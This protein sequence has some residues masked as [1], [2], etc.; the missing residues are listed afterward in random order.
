MNLK[1]LLVRPYPYMPTSKWLQTM[2]L[3][4]PYA[5]ELIAGAVQEPH[6][7]KICDLAVHKKP[8][9]AFKKALQEYQPD[10][11]GFGG[12][13]GQFRTNK[14]LAA[15]AKKILPE[16]VVCI[17][18]IHS[19]S[20][21]LDCKYPE[22]FDLVV[23]GDGVSAIKVIIAAMERGEKLP[24]SQWILQPASENFDEL[25]KKPPPALH[26]DGINT[27]PRRDLIDVS[28]Y[29]CLCYG[30]PGRKTKTLFPEI[31]CVRTSVGCPNRCSFCVVHF[32]ASGK[33]LQRK[34]EDVVD[35]IESLPQEYIYFVDDETFINT[36]RMSKIAEML[37]A[38]GIKKKYLSWARSDTICNHPEL[39]K[40]WKKAGL[41]FVYIGFES[42]K[43]E[44][45]NAYNKNATPSQNR[46][47]R[48]ILRDLNLNIHAALMINPD[49]EEEDFITVQKT[50]KEMA[51]AEFAFTIF[52]PP[53][54]TNDFHD[55]QD[56]FIC[57]DPCL[58]YDC[59]HTILPTKLP[60]RRF[61]RYFAILYAMGAAYVP[62]R[63]NK[64][65]VP[66]RDLYKFIWKGIKFG[67]HLKRL[68]RDYDKKYW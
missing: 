55:S 58:Y 50:I 43:E 44:T 25:A 11:I 57:E 42:L 14:E 26:P 34:V 10:F 3:L 38:R 24:E 47:A 48:E 16:A 41:E 52:S 37:I 23:R 56:N 39:F 19:S 68:Y 61:Y 15:I 64:V 67:W 17:G 59:L 1:I 53:P 45:L 51:P 21:P 35:E 60:L 31:A 28:K 2:L 27:K 22:L 54:G 9:A 5:Q 49:F 18:G 46:E 8:V 20:I 13:S 30:E 29:Y 7:V 65:K 6:D 66:F 33:Y 12:F 36:K 4:E 63:I 32:L 40:L 62:S